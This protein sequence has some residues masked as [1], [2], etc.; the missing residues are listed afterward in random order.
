MLVMELERSPDLLVRILLPPVLGDLRPRADPNVRDAADVLHE[1][2]ERHDTP[3]LANHAVVH[4]DGPADGLD[5]EQ[6]RIGYS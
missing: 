5:T 2:T 1:P 4:C 3:W 6:D